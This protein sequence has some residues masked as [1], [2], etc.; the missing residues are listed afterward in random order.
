MGQIST[1]TA[2][3]LL[4]GWNQTGQKYAGEPDIVKL[5]LVRYPQLLWI[6]SGIMYAFVAFRLLSGLQGLPLVVAT[7]LTSVLISAAFSFKLA[8]T[9]EDSPELVVGLVKTL[10]D[11][12]QGQ[13]L[14]SRA[15]LVF[16]LLSVVYAVGIYKSLHKGQPTSSSARESWPCITS[17]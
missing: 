2:L 1:L 15:R 5:F 11:N 7:T 14:L 12:F 3:R 17:Q 13:S 16:F 8:F 10:S 9:A 4:R 6:L